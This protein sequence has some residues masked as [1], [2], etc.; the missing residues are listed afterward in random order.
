M[1]T[2]ILISCHNSRPKSEPSPKILRPLN[3]AN[4]NSELRYI[5]QVDDVN[6]LITVLNDSSYL[7][8][9]HIGFTGEPSISYAYFSNV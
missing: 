8:A 6:K 5:S 2:I 7:E 4:N 9:E 3:F 1:L